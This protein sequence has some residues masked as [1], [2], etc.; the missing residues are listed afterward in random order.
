MAKKFRILHIGTLTIEHALSDRNDI[1]YDF[2]NAR[3]IEN[4]QINFED[5][6]EFIKKQ[7]SY[8]FI[9]VEYNYS[10]RMMQLLK[11]VINP[12]NTY[13]NEQFY[14]EEYQNDKLLNEMFVRPIGSQNRETLIDKV[15]SICFP[16]QYGDKKRPTQLMINP[17]FQGEKEYLGNKWLKLHGHFGETFQQVATL[18]DLLFY[19]KNKALEIWPEFKK[20]GDV[21]IEITFRIYADNTVD[22]LLKEIT[23]SEQQ[24]SEPF[25]IDVMTRN[26]FVS[27][28][29]KAKGEGI[30]YLG[31]VHRRWSRQEFGK[32]LLGGEIFKDE[33]RNEFIYFFSPGDMKPPLNVYFSGY[34][35]AEGFEGYFMMKK[36]GAPF[37]L[38]GDPRIEG[39]AFYIGKESYE[40]AIVRIIQEKLTY[41]NLQSHELILSGLSMG[42]FGAIY[43]GAQLN[44]A[45]VI[46][47]KPLVN[48]G[49][50]GQ[51]MKLL[52]PEEFGTS[53]DVLLANT[54]GTTQHHIHQLNQKFWD[55]FN[56]Y[57]VSHTTFAICYMEDD[58]Y[59]LYAFN[60]LLEVLSK[61]HAHVISRGVP[62]RHNDDSPTINNWFINFFH[63]LMESKFGRK[64]L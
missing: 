59:D 63:I 50:V 34:R 11:E 47:G 23:V 54:G 13:V 61:N 18:N 41:L 39:G 30:L 10:D 3:I 35:T 45:A 4:Q 48:I 33:D 1:H 57:D 51:N 60:D 19:E 37:I 26:A 9:L 14:S 38:I 27:Y 49:T 2:L 42:S 15:K 53:L 6:T 12:F 43:Y 24:L 5:V 31:A 62:G 29:V 36:L 64:R 46:V 40:K 32:F 20:E 22:N 16:G 55:T 28:S 25:K 56:N 7:K 44:P 58:D 17:S 21:V 8:D 52:R